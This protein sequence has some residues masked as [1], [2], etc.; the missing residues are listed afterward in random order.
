MRSTSKALLILLVACGAASAQQRYNV[1]TQLNWPPSTGH[2]FPTVPCSAT[3]NQGQPNYG[4]PYTDIDGSVDYTCGA[5]GWFQ[6]SG[7]AAI[8]FTGPWS[9]TRTYNVSPIPQA[10]GYN[11]S[12]YV[13]L[14]NNNLNHNPATATTYWALLVTGSGGI[15]QLTGD[16]TTPAGSG[17]QT[18]T[19][20]TG[21]YGGPGTCGDASH[22]SQVTI[23][24]KG[25]TTGCTAVPISASGGA[26]GPAGSVQ[27]QSAV[28]GTN[29]ASDQ[30][31]VLNLLP[32]SEYSQAPKNW[33]AGFLACLYNSANQVCSIKAFGDSFTRCYYSMCGAGPQSPAN[34][35]P[36]RLMADLV[37]AGYAS[38]GTGMV[39][40]FANANSLDP[41]WGT[42]GTVTFD[43]NSL[44]PYETGTATITGLA[45][46]ANGAV[47]T[48]TTS[49]PYDT[50]DIFFGTLA[51]ETL[52][53]QIDGSTVG[54]GSSTS[55]TTAGV[56]NG[57]M[58]A[59]MLRTSSVTLGTHTTTVTCSA[60]GG[61]CFFYAAKFTSGSVG[62]EVSNLAV[63]GSDST[64]WG[65]APTTQEAFTDIDPDGTALAISHIA[66]ND[67]NAATPVNTYT[68]QVTALVTHEKALSA[69]L[70]TSFLLTVPGIPVDPTFTML[71]PYNAASVAMAKTLPVGFA[72]VN[73]RTGPTSVLCTGTVTNGSNT[74]TAV[75][76]CTGTLQTGMPILGSG[77]PS[78]GSTVGYDFTITAIGSNTIT[79][80]GN[81]T[82][83]ATATQI[84]AFIIASNYW[85]ATSGFY[86]FTHPGD[87]LTQDEASMFYDSAVGAAGAGSASSI[88]GCTSDC[89]FGGATFN[90]ALSGTAS[91]LGNLNFLQPALGTGNFFDIAIGKAVSAH[92][93]FFIGW[94]Q[95]SSPFA[96]ITTFAAADPIVFGDNASFFPGGTYIGNTAW[97]PGTPVPT[98]GAACAGLSVGTTNQWCTDLSGSQTTSGNMTVTGSGTITSPTIHTTAGVGMGPVPALSSYNYISVNSSAVQATMVGIVGTSADPTMYLY[99]P[100]TG[101]FNF[102]VDGTGVADISAAGLTVSAYA[103][104]KLP[105]CVTSGVITVGTNTTGVL[106]CP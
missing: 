91:S 13:S 72:N 75:S 42:S 39:P 59:R 16:V 17:V 40:L 8:Q 96:S 106:A 85:D 14:Q 4:Q 23:D 94:S 48:Y 60:G 50:V 52:T 33:A 77:I 83:S 21:I 63:G 28:A 64:F 68:T 90:V 87:V 34:R 45:H 24:N 73:D 25:R 44:G 18:A 2:G 80:S 19:L 53:V 95:S 67:A 43:N 49:V 89:T 27:I 55:F 10:V 93:A 26:V 79:M 32:I 7:S 29:A 62:V 103:G 105:L 99:V 47:A 15:T 9:S 71:A 30:T 78:T 20:A 46:L 69:A 74:I 31:T 58:T 3:A 11:G 100:I 12:T 102:A 54:T 81:A 5:N 37:A 92:S 38:H 70:P 86:Q 61:G 97:T 88:G 98:A 104:T 41:S 22:V 66:I 51:S 1:V 36:S 35:W 84:S 76:G 82:G 57:G 101:S 6:S 65:F 56:S